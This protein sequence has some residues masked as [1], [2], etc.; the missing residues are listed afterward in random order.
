MTTMRSLKKEGAGLGLANHFMISVVFTS[1]AIASSKESAPGGEGGTILF[2]R[3]VIAIDVVNRE[4]LAVSVRLV[5]L[6]TAFPPWG[7]WDDDRKH[8]VQCYRACYF[9]VFTVDKKSSSCREC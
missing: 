2:L 7:V 5:G 9:G 3:C 4:V 6:L 1:I 8:F